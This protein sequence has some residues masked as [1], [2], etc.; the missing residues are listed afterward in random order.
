MMCMSGGLPGWHM[1]KEFTGDSEDLNSIPG[2]GLSPGGR[3]G[4]LF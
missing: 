4:N 1:G 3:N 2:S